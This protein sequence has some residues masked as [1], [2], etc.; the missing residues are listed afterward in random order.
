MTLPYEIL[1][2]IFYEFRGISHQTSSVIK[3]AWNN[4]IKCNNNFNI[5]YFMNYKRNKIIKELNS[6]FK[7]E[8]T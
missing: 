1:C 5:N 8:K 7:I 4:G 3:N 2:K 6:K